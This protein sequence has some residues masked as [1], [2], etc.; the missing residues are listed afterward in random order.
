MDKSKYEKAFLYLSNI[1]ILFLGK[2]KE[3]EKRTVF[4]LHSSNIYIL[5]SVKLKKQE[6]GYFLFCILE[7][8]LLYLWAIVKEMEKRMFF[9]LCSGKI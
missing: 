8:I 7:R 5:G 4:V 9:I 1:F 3:I 2:I 6:I